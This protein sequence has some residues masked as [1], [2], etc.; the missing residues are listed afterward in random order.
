MQTIERCFVLFVSRSMW[1]SSW[2]CARS[3][4]FSTP[5]WAFFC[6]IK[7]RVELLKLQKPSKN[8]ESFHDAWKKQQQQRS[9]NQNAAQQKKAACL[10]SPTTTNSTVSLQFS[11]PFSP[12][13]THSHFSLFVYMMQRASILKKYSD[14]FFFCV[15]EFLSTPDSY[16][17]RNEHKYPNAYIIESAGKSKK[18]LLHRYVCSPSVYIHWVWAQ[19]C[20]IL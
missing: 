18:L 16:M 1:F 4:V 12:T 14:P 13:A 5:F 8:V 9:L 6:A 11:A 20:N 19:A 17:A 2:R 10:H 7:T 15:S 3:F